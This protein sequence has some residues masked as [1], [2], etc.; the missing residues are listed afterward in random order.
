ILKG[1]DSPVN[2]DGKS[3]AVKSNVAQGA[4]TLVEYKANHDIK[5][6][7]PKNALFGKFY[8]ISLTK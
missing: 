4:G 5:N 1:I 7:Q 6:N 2:G 8:E 3:L